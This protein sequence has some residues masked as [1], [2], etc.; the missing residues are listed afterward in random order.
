MYVELWSYYVPEF[1]GIARTMLA[2]REI[3]EATAWDDRMGVVHKLAMAI[4]QRLYRRMLALGLLG[5][6]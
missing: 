5:R 4:V 1:C 3:D 6:V 2:A